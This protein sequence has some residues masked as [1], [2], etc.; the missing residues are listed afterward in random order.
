MAR[1]QK[2]L[3]IGLDSA[4]LGFWQKYGHEGRTPNLRSLMERGV[5]MKALPAFPPATAVNWNTIVTGAYAGN[6]NMTAMVRLGV[7][8]P[9]DPRPDADLR[10]QVSGFFSTPRTAETLWEVAEKQG[11]RVLLLKY[12]TSWPPTLK[13]GL[14]VE[15]FS[16]PAWSIFALAPRMSFAT[17]NL[18]SSKA[19]STGAPEGTL[20]RAYK[21]VVRPAR[22]WRNLP[23]KG[24]SAL[25]ACL[26]FSTRGGEKELYALLT[27]GAQGNY[28]RLVLCEARD[29]RSE[30]AEVFPGQWSKW[31]RSAFPLHDN[32][33]EGFF[34]VKLMDL[35]PDG[36]K[37]HLYMSQVFPV[38][39]WTVPASLAR[40]LSEEVGP[41]QE[42][43]GV[44]KPY[45]LGWVD[46]QTLIDEMTY[47]VDWL[48]RAAAYLMSKGDW[49][50]F[51]TQ[52]H[53]IDH[54]DHLFLGGTD[55]EA[56]FYSPGRQETCETM[57]ARTYELAD[58]YVGHLLRL[59]DE[60]TLVVVT[61]D[62][63]HLPVRAPGLDVNDIL[64]KQGLLKYKI[65]K[66]HVLY[67]LSPV[68]PKEID[69]ANSLAAECQEGYI[70]VNLKGRNPHGIVEPDD[71]E[72]VRDRVI[73][74][75]QGAL[76]PE[77][78]EHPA[79]LV[80]RK[81]EARFLGIHGSNVG[82]VIFCAKTEFSRPMAKISPL[83]DWGVGYASTGNHHGYIHSSGFEREEWTMLA[84]TVV[85][86]P[87]VVKGLQRQSPINLV[88]IAPTVC[89]L[90]GLPAPRQSEG[91]ILWDILE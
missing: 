62:H 91:Q 38:D 53:G 43:G 72:K 7:D 8:D 90:L 27:S 31:T 17:F 52:W 57:I 51:I 76:N 21:I 75:V 19:S 48:G 81:E 2:L 10:K 56:I 23:E 22:G 33:A 88:D 34:R 39:G 47:Q 63:G 84:C 70:Y 83:Q 55:P 49:Q 61:S 24:G 64:E 69:W 29:T 35:S 26:R 37:L 20:P 11:N 3:L 78:G 65:A 25:E 36:S 44:A 5:S 60:E 42:L 80:L 50:L 28:D 18:P 85:A 73:N 77:V 71:Y 15:G 4:T 9:L 6:H 68:G 58:R 14:Q 89:H 13:E 86:G 74:A 32:V 12:P 45:Q 82:D 87:G 79:A 59:V 16:D 40:E 67:P 30:L 54:M 41:F 66:A 1:A 46:E